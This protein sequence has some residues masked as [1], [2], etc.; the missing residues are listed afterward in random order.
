MRP[1]RALAAF[2]LAAGARAQGSLGGSQGSCTSAQAWA[3]RGCYGDVSNGNNA[4]FTFK[5]IGSASPSDPHYYPGYTTGQVSIDICLQGCRGHGFRFAAL[6]GGTDCYCGTIKPTTQ[7][8]GSSTTNNNTLNECHVTSLL[9]G[10]CQG[11]KQEWCGSSVAS[12]VYEDTSFP[13]VALTA[14][15]GNYAYV[16]CFTVTSPGDLV[17]AT[18]AANTAACQSAC[19]N[20]GYPFAGMSDKGGVTNACQCGTEIQQGS[21]ASTGQSCQACGAGDNG[22]SCGGL[23]SGTPLL[24][25]YRNTNLQG[26]YSPKVPSSSQTVT[27]T[28]QTVT[29]SSQTATSSSA[30]SMAPHLEEPHAIQQVLTAGAARRVVTVELQMPTVWSPMDVS[31]AA[32]SHHQQHL[33]RTADAVHHLV[34]LLAIPMELSAGAVVVADTAEVLLPSRYHGN[35]DEPHH[36]QH[37]EQTGGAVHP[38]VG[39]PVT[40]MELTEGVAQAVDI[41]GRVLRMSLN[42]HPC[43]L[44][45]N[46]RLPEWLCYWGPDHDHNNDNTN[47]NNDDNHYYYFIHVKLFINIF[48]SCW[49][50]GAES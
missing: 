37:L 46:Q 47:A 50:L 36:Q 35:I 17:Y 11:N 18:T 27:S 45:G 29:S 41:A 7:T 42:V 23:A 8:L 34:G 1:I 14:Q 4:G 2:A 16:G 44:F 21:P 24:T 33:E 40:Q 26:C 39:R 12:D 43:T 22:V 31:R 19:A 13:T 10:G 28:S 32:Q 9:S 30:T 20:L 15:G 25:V 6:H 48:N 5:L 49:R 38:L 3:Y